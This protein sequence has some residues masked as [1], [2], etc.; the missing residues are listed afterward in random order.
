MIYV[1]YPDDP[2]TTFLKE[3]IT[4]LQSASVDIFV[5]NVGASDD[6]YEQAYKEV[7]NIS[8]SSFIIFMGHGTDDELLGG[9]SLD[10]KRKPFIKR[11]EMRIFREK[12]LIL[13]SCN[14]EG[15]IKSSR[16]IAGFSDTLSFGA[17]PTS[18]EEVENDSKLK[19]LGITEDII[20]EYKELLVH[21]MVESVLYA[22]QK[23]SS[24]ELVY[25]YLRLCIN[26]KISELVLCDK[27]VL[28]NLLFQMKQ[29]MVYC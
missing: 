5:I 25:N 2:S 17:L 29:E 18:V 22:W 28:A 20:S 9:E 1:V 27:R 7:D 26:R 14:S 16:R 6:S 11:N 8:E 12:S 3:I 15:L 21:F 10:F 13:L 24:L 19:K 4:E 23:G